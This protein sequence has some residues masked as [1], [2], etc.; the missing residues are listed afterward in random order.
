MK[1][2]VAATLFCATI[3]FP[4]VAQGPIAAMAPRAPASPEAAA[5]AANMVP[6]SG[7]EA[8]PVGGEPIYG[9]DMAA[10]GAGGKLGLP[11]GPAPSLAW[12]FALAFLGLIILR[13]TRSSTA[14]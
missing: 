11:A 9:G 12:L 6:V 8:A 14:F 5:A 7:A 13:R 4:A 3:A 2:Y 1:K 10:P